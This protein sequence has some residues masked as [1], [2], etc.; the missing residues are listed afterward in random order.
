M[1]CASAVLNGER[2]YHNNLLE[3]VFPGRLILILFLQPAQFYCR[4][5]ISRGLRLSATPVLMIGHF[6]LVLQIAEWYSET[7]TRQHFLYIEEFRLAKCIML[8]SKAPSVS[9]GQIDDIYSAT[10]AMEVLRHKRHGKG[11]YGCEIM[12]TFRKTYF[13]INI[14]DWHKHVPNE[15]CLKDPHI[16]L[17]RLVCIFRT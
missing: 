8:N 5:Y 13:I 4:H 14:H 15:T 16:Y 9:W 1:W 7:I 12:L 10:E 2:S 17:Y 11:A 3:V 6:L